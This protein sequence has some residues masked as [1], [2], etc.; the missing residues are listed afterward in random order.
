MSFKLVYYSQ[1]DPQWKT[2]LLGFGD[3]GDTIGTYGCALTS[4]AM[5]VSGHGYTETPKTLNQK[6]KN[7]NGFVSSGIRWDVVAQVHPEITLKENILCENSD[8]PLARINAALDAGQ[9]VVVRVDSSPAPGLQWH[10]VMIYARKGNDDYLMLDP[11]PYS[12]GTDKQD[13]LMARY[14]RGNPLKRAIQQVLIYQS[15]TSGGPISLPSSDETDDTAPSQPQPGPVGEGPRARAKAELTWGL[16]IRS[17]PDSSSPANIVVSVPAGTELL[18][19]DAD[20]PS[21]I[22]KQEW[23]RVRE[24][25]GKQGYAAA[26][27]LDLVSDG[28]PAPAPEPTPGPGNEPPAPT[29]PVQVRVTASLLRIRSSADTSS[30][31]NIITSVPSG[32]VLTLVNASDESKI[33]VNVQWVRVRTTQGQE[34]FT[35]AWYLQKV[36]STPGTPSTPDIHRTRSSIG[37][38]LENVAM[39][40][41]ANQRIND[42]GLLARIW[43]TYGGLLTAIANKM[44]FD[45]A[46]AV[47][48]IAQESGGQAYGADGRLLIRFENHLFYDN[49]GTQHPTVYNAHFQTGSPRWTGHKWRPTANGV[50]RDV[51]ASQSSEWDVFT[52]AR[53]LD[54]DAAKKSISIGLPQ[55]LG[56]NYGILGFASVDDM[57]NAFVA[58]ERN[59][60]VAF[61]D[62]LQGNGSSATNALRNR[63]FRT[64]ATIYNGAGNAD[65]YARLIKG[66]Y[67]SFIK[68]RGSP[69][70]S[71]STPSPSTPTT[72]EPTPP[73]DPTKK[74]LVVSEAAGAAGI[75]LRQ[76]AS[77]SAPSQMHLTPGML[78]IVI[79]PY[80]KAKGKLDKIGQWIY[81]RGPNKKLGYV[82][83]Q[84]VKL[85]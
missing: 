11:W 25:G 13:S 3:A 47:A 42:N 16:N 63:D 70:P 64:I 81:V 58:S 12:P 14:S 26:W 62:F 53:T 7:K 36:E 30:D 24:P 34:G 10:Y 54:D 68:L 37:D 45:V 18:L 65:L 59:Q 83:S 33:G 50:W 29:G 49:W 82:L 85:P 5:L 52:Y 8:A 4:V 69:S 22:G 51:H 1:Q 31:A 79:E 78:L 75:E 67:D 77:D 55:V 60:V 41:P 71:P 48:I 66:H 21:K 61:F 84:F 46:I 74:Y 72:P 17:S 57:F 2:D 38:G 44:T 56:S 40:A 28:T 76:K 35:A 43:N 6:L 39:P 9:P 19:L 23:V 15:S 20:G 73:M 27:Y 32:T 80:A